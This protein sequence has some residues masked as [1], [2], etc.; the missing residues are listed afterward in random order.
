MK[1]FGKKK[2]EIPGIKNSR[3]HRFPKSQKKKKKII[4]GPIK[5]KKKKKKD[6]FCFDRFVCSLLV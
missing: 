5:K 1:F 2:P 6:S 4:M 3:K